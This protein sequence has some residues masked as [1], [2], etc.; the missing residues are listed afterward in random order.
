MFTLYAY[1]KF[2]FFS[3]PPL[4][5]LIA[6]TTVTV[7]VETVVRVKDSPTVL[8]QWKPMA[9]VSRGRTAGEIYEAKTRV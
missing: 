1:R 3:N 2:N 5:G 8:G 9:L 7:A 4:V 6:R